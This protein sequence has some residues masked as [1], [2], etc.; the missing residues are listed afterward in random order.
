MRCMASVSYRVGLNGC[1]NDM[2]VPSRGLKQGDPMSPYLFL[3]CVEGFSTLLEQAKIQNVVKG[4]RLGRGS[5]AINHLFFADGSLLFGDVSK[6]GTENV[7]K[8]IYI[9]E[10]ALGYKVNY[11]KSILYF[12]KNA[13]EE[14]RASLTAKLG[15]RVATNPEK[16][17]GLPIMVGRKRKRAFGNN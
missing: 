12:G 11:D 8:I 9:Y 17:L 13:T 2:F 6:E 3:I 14:D 16:Y 1:F 15:V 7:H 10:G 4:V 5:L